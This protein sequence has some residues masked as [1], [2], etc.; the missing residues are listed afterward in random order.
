M[1]VTGLLL[2]QLIEHV[3]IILA[4]LSLHPA[5]YP[6]VSPSHATRGLSSAL[7]IGLGH[8][9]HVARLVGTIPVPSADMKRRF[10]STYNM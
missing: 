4:L 10:V 1:A 7:I 8:L 2:Q 9:T 5:H 3:R 6:G